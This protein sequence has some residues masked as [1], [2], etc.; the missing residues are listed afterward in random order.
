MPRELERRRSGQ[1]GKDEGRR[2]G[3]ERESVLPSVRARGRNYRQPS[4][5]G[6]SLRPWEKGT[7]GD[8][9]VVNSVVWWSRGSARV[10]VFFLSKAEA[11]VE[12][13]LELPLS[14]SILVAQLI[15]RGGADMALPCR[16]KFLM[17]ARFQ[18]RDEASRQG[19]SDSV[20]AHLGMH[21][22]TAKVPSPPSTSRKP[23]VRSHDAHGRT[24]PCL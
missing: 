11:H 22:Q 15:V 5:R 9:G 7:E 1:D 17:P 19:C 4:S 23:F 18:A 6:S 20:T 14:T 3:G 12:G 21:V 8:I 10:F 13:L 2:I 16:Y 24:V